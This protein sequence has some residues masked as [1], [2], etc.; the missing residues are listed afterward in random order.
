MDDVVAVRLLLADGGTAYMMTWGRTLSEVDP[1]PLEALISEVA[2]GFSLRSVATRVEVCYSIAEARDAP[3]FYEAVMSFSAAMATE[4]I[5]SKKW[6]RTQAERMFA[7]KEIFYMGRT[8]ERND[9][10]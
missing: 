10:S 8:L 2:S 4:R 1:A 9:G 7:G 3:Y 5:N 6:K